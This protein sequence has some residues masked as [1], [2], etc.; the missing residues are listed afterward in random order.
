MSLKLLVDVLDGG[1]WCG[2]KPPGVR[3]PR[4]HLES[5]AAESQPSAWRTVS[6]AL[7]AE[8]VVA[9]FA[10]VDLYRLAQRLQGD[11]KGALSDATQS[12]FDGV[13]GS[14]PISVII[15]TL[16]NLI[17]PPP[18]PWQDRIRFA[19]NT[20]ELAST[21]QGDVKSQLMKSAVGILREGIVS[22]K[23][24]ADTAGARR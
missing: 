18:P 20:L 21:A 11:E 23:A 7:S 12:Y 2:T 1:P 24:A 15:A 4:P 19:G 16:L 6:S 9:A 5:A 10:A 22:L 3:G 8:Q 13:C 17:P 14:V